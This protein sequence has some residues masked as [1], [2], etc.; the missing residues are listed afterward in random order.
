MLARDSEFV[1]AAT[2]EDAAALAEGSAGSLDATDRAAR[3][4]FADLIRQASRNA[5]ALDGVV[6]AS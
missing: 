1:G 3:R 4:E 5:A 2:A 6:A